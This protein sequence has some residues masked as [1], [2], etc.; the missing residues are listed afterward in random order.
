MASVI[1]EAVRH[2]RLRRRRTLRRWLERHRVARTVAR[3][4]RVN[5]DLSEA[6]ALGLSLIFI[7]MVLASQFESF[8]HPFTIMASLPLS[9]PFGLLSLLATG[10]TMNIVLQGGSTSA[11]LND[12]DEH[13]RCVYDS[14]A[15]RNGAGT[16][17]GWFCY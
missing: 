15:I 9:M 1:D 7:Y 8:V 11:L 14:H 3:A 6:I 4:V 5:E 2:V 10:F 12:Q 17:P 16:S 13:L